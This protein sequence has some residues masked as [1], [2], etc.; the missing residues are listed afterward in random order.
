MSVPLSSTSFIL[1]W[2]QPL[3]EERSGD[4][5]GYTINVTN[6]NTELIQQ[7]LVGLI[8]NYT[9]SNLKPFTIYVST[10]SARTSIGLGPYSALVY[11]TT[12]EDGMF[13]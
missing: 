1:N 4:I 6:L 13:D 2:E 8:S 12:L 7:F 10:I 3:Q 5:V 9:V 11:V